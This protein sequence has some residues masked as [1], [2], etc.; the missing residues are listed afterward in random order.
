M[1]EQSRDQCEADQKLLKLIAEQN[2]FTYQDILDGTPDILLPDDVDRLKDQYA[3]HL[4]ETEFRTPFDFV[5]LLVSK[6]S[7]YNYIVPYPN[8]VPVTFL[9]ET[10]H[11]FLNNKLPKNTK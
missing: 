3:K 5:S 6:P 7:S 10:L 9:K 1:L 2:N 4:K 11:P 8:F